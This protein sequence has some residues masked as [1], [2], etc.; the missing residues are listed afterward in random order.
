M[1]WT[2]KRARAHRSRQAQV[3]ANAPTYV[4]RFCVTPEK[5]ARAIVSRRKPGTRARISATQRK[6]KHPVSLPKFSWDE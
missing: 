2:F 1:A 4:H 3:G 6:S 5:L